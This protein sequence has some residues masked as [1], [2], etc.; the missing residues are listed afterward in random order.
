[1]Q[2]AE[3]FQAAGLPVFPCWDNKVPAVSRGQDWRDISQQAPA[4]L[5]WPSEVIGVP[6][7][8]GCV[9]ID[10]DT[11]KGVTRA[12]VE[13]HLGCTL[14][15]DAAL[16][17]ITQNGGEHYAFA[18]D[19]PVR[20][21]DS[22][23]GVTGLDTRCAG[24]GYIC[25]GG[26]YRPQGF[27]PMRMAHPETLPRLPEAARTVLERVERRVAERPELPTG[28]RD[29][30]ALIAAL[31]HIDPG[32]SRS[33]WVRVGLGLRHHFHDE[34][35]TGES[36]FEAWSSGEFWK[37]GAPEN[38]VP[39][40][41]EGQ[42]AS[43]KPEGDTTIAT[44]YY[45]AMQNGWRPP[46]A[47]DTALAFGPDACGAD[48][49]EALVDR[50]NAHGSDSRHTEGLVADIQQSGCNA[51]Q[52]TLLR[53]EL[54]AALRDGQL[55]DKGLAAVIDQQLTPQA[56][57]KPAPVVKGLQIQ[58]ISRPSSTQHGTNALG[59][60]GEIYGDN[61][62]V[63]SGVLRWWDGCA[64]RSVASDTLERVIWAALLPDH[65]K[66]STVTGTRDAIKALAP[67]RD[68]RTTDR[69]TYFRN[70]VLD[71][72]TGEFCAHH[73]DNGNLGTLACDWDPTAQCPNWHGFVAS[74][75]GGEE[76]GADRMALLQE[77]LG[78]SLI[79]DALNLQKIIAFDGA[80]R[81][82]KGVIFE[83][84]LAMLGHDTAG[85]TT[86]S[87][88]DDGKTQSAFRAFDVMFDFEAEPPA[89][90]S[91]KTAI[92]FM[93]KL[94]SNEVVSIQLLNQQTPW[95]GR[96]DCKMFIA[97]NGIPT[98]LDDSGA[99]S[100]RFQV[101]RF[102]RSFS[103]REDKTLV[104]RLIGE[105]PGIAAW[106]VSGLCRLLANG[107]NFTTPAT[108]VDAVADLRGANQ[109]LRDF[110]SEYLEIDP[111]GRCHSK[112]IW[113]SYRIYCIDNNVK[114]PTRNTFVRSLEKT[115][116]GTGAKKKTAVRV[117]G[118]VSTGFEGL[119][120][121]AA[122]NPFAPQLEAVQ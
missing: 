32:C 11:Y 38:Y 76:D 101:L 49:F 62:A 94:A 56:P 67:R 7:P 26:P 110:I 34:E 10:L 27:G 109:P 35:Y 113:Q 106:A 118:K 4:T 51:L 54:K 98:M 25:T 92:G 30:D 104:P 19:W 71:P 105:L 91:I 99:T 22:L 8:A 60:M 102:T 66:K 2:I 31:R 112:D 86:F 68:E 107:G 103:D 48:V 79:R 117:E 24:K 100:N 89:R 6:V 40:H 33:E 115:L 1:M 69:R 82:G 65:S 47:F 83:V 5:R 72:A 9:V 75:F 3:Q 28:G 57:P 120:L 70:G 45:A 23:D 41:M 59:I 63:I 58:Q 36:I 42:W 116:L 50:I 37:D 77:I 108:T 84:M 87:N 85:V 14:D 93:N 52:A 80:S 61:L 81:A 122:G 114:L 12:A 46:A 29:I 119:S 111:R 39:E 78:W 90:Q 55:L 43:F 18:V 21:G 64:W 121:T 74:I 88:L 95:Q 13:L 44:V 20:Q 16:L 96:L 17:Q 15:W 97:C 53:N 73:I